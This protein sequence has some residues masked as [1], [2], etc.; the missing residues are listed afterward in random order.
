VFN[1]AL[2]GVSRRRHRMDL[3]QLASGA[4]VVEDDPP[5]LRTAAISLAFAL[6]ALN[7]LDLI[8]TNFNI[9]NYG[10]VEV[11]PVMAPLIGTPWAVVV[12]IGIPLGIIALTQWGGSAR[13]LRMLRVAVAIYVVI[14]IV[15]VGQLA[16]A[17]V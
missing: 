2:G 6:L 13:M 14:A 7:L 10:A 12:K 4:R 5:H 3:G 17:L 15:G 8:V 16:N 9:E 11:N 1:V